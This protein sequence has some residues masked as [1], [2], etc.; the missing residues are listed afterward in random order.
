M[1]DKN[2][3]KRM[4]SFYVSDIHLATMILPYLSEK[5]EKGEILA[6][7]LEKDIQK[8]MELLLEKTNIKEN[9]KK[10]I[11]NINWNKTNKIKYSDIEKYINKFKINKTINIL[12][13]GTIEYIK[14][15]NENLKK[16]AEKNNINI[17]VINAYELEENK[18]K[19]S[20]IINEYKYMLNTSGEHL[21][22]DVFNTMDNM[23]K[24]EII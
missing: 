15:I 6:T 13:V 23:S 18:E 3:F 8:E 17:N 1:L 14:I 24:K 10:A 16:Y 7:F 22:T 12:N 21:V 4:C 9:I 11:E 19:F 20:E 5:I 2:N